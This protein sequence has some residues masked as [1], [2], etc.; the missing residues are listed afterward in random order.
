MP[1]SQFD[2]L[3]RL[4]HYAILRA[5]RFTF[6]TFSQSYK[7]SEQLIKFDITSTFQKA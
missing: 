6:N 3:W 7:I 5:L 2:E 1:V 4:E